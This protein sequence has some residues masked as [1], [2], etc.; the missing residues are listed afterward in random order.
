M[1]LDGAHRQGTAWKAHPK[2]TVDL[3]LVQLAEPATEPPAVE[4]RCFL[5]HSDAQHMGRIG[6][7]IL[8]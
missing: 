5:R 1:R 6:E 3:A 4:V 7:Q 2:Q 8:N